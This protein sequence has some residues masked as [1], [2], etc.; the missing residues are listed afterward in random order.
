MRYH[1]L[2]ELR[3]HFPGKIILKTHGNHILPGFEDKILTHLPPVPLR[4]ARTDDPTTYTVNLRL[5][6]MNRVDT[7]TTNPIPQDAYHALDR[8]PVL[9]TISTPKPYDDPYTAPRGTAFWYDQS[10][11]VPNVP[12]TTMLM[13]V[14]QNSVA[15]S[16]GSYITFNSGDIT[17]NF[18]NAFGFGGH[19][20]EKD[21][22]IYQYNPNTKEGY[23]E[24][25]GVMY[26]I[27]T[28]DAPIPGQ[29]QPYGPS[30]LPD[31]S[32]PGLGLGQFDVD[33]LNE[34]TAEHTNLGT[35]TLSY[36]KTAFSF[37]AIDTTAENGETVHTITTRHHT[38]HTGK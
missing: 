36:E 32:Y 33:M 3:A 4:T 17:A 28:Y 10:F 2:E 18:I 38:K 1:T 14:L 19:R 22:G 9:P 5:A 30:G 24:G 8:R 23:W 7:G 12:G 25:W 6:L 16:A 37:T 13:T 26:F 31:T 34:T 11:S 21:A 35:F 27:G 29:E 15:A 20:F